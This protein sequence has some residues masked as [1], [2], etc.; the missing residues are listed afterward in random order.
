MKGIVREL[1]FS[2]TVRQEDIESSDD[3]PI[4]STFT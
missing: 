4:T 3:Y 2:V 1:R